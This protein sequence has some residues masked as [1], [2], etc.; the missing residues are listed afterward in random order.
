MSCRWPDTEWEN[1]VTAVF[2]A[3]SGVR[4]G[5]GNSGS[6]DTDAP[7]QFG[8]VLDYPV[9]Q[10]TPPFGDDLVGAAFDAVVGLTMAE[11]G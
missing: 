8:P 5:P 1:R 6:G 2:A 10:Q 11:M 3:Y 7:G 4:Q 9:I